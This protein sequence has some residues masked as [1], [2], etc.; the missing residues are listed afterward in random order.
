MTRKEAQPPRSPK[1]LTKG[2][3]R[4]PHQTHAISRVS[5]TKGGG[6]KAGGSL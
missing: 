3:G 6:V 1:R 2:A 4:C 5:M